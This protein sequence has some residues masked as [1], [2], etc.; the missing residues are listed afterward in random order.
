[1]IAG[2]LAYNGIGFRTSGT[3]PIAYTLTAMSFGNPKRR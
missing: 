2:A 1:M 3:L